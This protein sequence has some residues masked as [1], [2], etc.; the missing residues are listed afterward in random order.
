MDMVT[1]LYNVLDNAIESCRKV[2]E[3]RYI[4]FSMKKTRDRELQIV[5]RNSRAD[6]VIDAVVCQKMRLCK[7][8]ESV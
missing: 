3:G 4:T 2:A 5:C 8:Q 6:E 7:G 1:V